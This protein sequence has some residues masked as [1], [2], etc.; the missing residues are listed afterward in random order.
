MEKDED[1]SAREERLRARCYNF[2]DISE[3]LNSERLFAARTETATK[4]GETR[5]IQDFS[6]LEPR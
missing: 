4:L 2:L 1:V 6:L 5:E 3:R